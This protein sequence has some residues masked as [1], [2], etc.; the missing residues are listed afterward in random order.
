MILFFLAC[1]SVQSVPTPAPIPVESIEDES[2]NSE[3]SDNIPQDR[4]DEQPSSDESI[5]SMTWQDC[6]GTLDINFQE[7]TFSWE[8]PDNACS[9]VG[10]L[11]REGEYVSFAA[12][13]S[14]NCEGPPWWIQA[15][16]HKIKHQLTYNNER[17]S[18]I[19]QSDK[20][21]AYQVEQFTK[22]IYSTSWEITSDLGDVSR[23]TLC[24][25][26][27]GE[28]WGGRYHSATDE[29]NFISCGGGITEVS[30]TPRGEHW[31][32]ECGG[33]C[34]CSGFVT[35]IEQNENPSAEQHHLQGVYHASN[36][37]MVSS[38]TFTGELVSP[39][40]RLGQ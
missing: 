4:N 24:T 37:A 29:C 32:T 12:T 13:D 6:S 36:C 1:E 27:N 17:L 39:R 11:Q 5:E 9:L 19:P 7:S 40:A 2:D 34:P 18:L 15:D 14:E 38:G 33:E 30:V 25:D 23:F 21:V 10:S 8:E 3:N 31:R 22:E 28:S 35:I 20:S 26:E 16:D